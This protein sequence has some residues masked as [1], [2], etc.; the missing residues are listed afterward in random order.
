MFTQQSLE[1]TSAPA[2]KAISLVASAVMDLGQ[3]NVDP[4][5]LL[6]WDRRGFWRQR[7][8]REY[9]SRLQSICTVLPVFYLDKNLSQL[10]LELHQSASSDCSMLG[11]H[12][13]ERPALLLREPELVHRVLGP[14]R[15]SFRAWALPNV[16]TDPL[17]RLCPP[18]AADCSWMQTCFSEGRLRSLFPVLKQI[19]AGLVSDT[20]RA[21]L[22]LNAGTAVTAMPSGIASKYATELMVRVGLGLNPGASPASGRD[23]ALRCAQAIEYVFEVSGPVDGLRQ[24]L[25]FNAPGLAGL[26]ATRLVPPSLEHDFRALVRVL[27]YRRGRADPELSKYCVM[28]WVGETL[29]LQGLA[30]TVTHERLVQQL[31]AFFVETYIQVC[32][33]GSFALQRL[34]WHPE[35]QA[36]VRVQLADAGDVGGPSFSYDLLGSLS[37]LEQVVQETERLAPVLGCLARVCTVSVQL[38]GRDGQ[39]CR[40]RPGELV[41]VSRLGLQTDERFWHDPE[42]FE[43]RRFDR[44]EEEREG[45]EDAIRPARPN[46]AALVPTDSSDA[47]AFHRMAL[48]MLLATLLTETRLL[49]ENSA[50]ENASLLPCSH[51]S[52]R[53]RVLIR[54]GD[55]NAP[56]DE[57]EA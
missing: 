8:L 55:I 40:L 47:R 54:Y 25:G 27:S 14:L 41:F 6:C 12:F 5:R 43:P 19:C 9:R 13:L 30:C 29:R 51:L 52:A 35:D 53:R 45:E 32:V 26:L 16:R 10:C 23:L 4:P 46:T 36:R 34:A 3:R 49:R 37:Y 31:F 50:P 1:S 38:Q 24:T 44:E 33:L 7:G 18:F 20:I 57:D 2:R 56:S 22:A 21:Q 11:F 39:R 15:S 17:L 42:R 48:K 28:H